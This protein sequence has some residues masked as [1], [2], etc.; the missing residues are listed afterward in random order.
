[1]PP[2]KCRDCDRPQCH[3]VLGCT[4]P[5][6]SPRT[7][8][9][10]STMIIVAINTNHGTNSIKLRLPVRLSSTAPTTPPRT[11]GTRRSHNH[12]CPNTP[13]NWLR[14]R[15]TAAG[16]A[17]N[18]ATALVASAVTGAT[19]SISQWECDQP[20]PTGQ[21]VDRSRHNIGQKQKD[22]G[23]R[24]LFLLILKELRLPAERIPHGR[25]FTGRG[26]RSTA[27]CRDL[28]CHR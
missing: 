28:H 8:I 2:G 16:Y 5:L 20:A 21:R 4:L 3:R 24:C 15:Q 10:L 9:G 23:Y 7:R 27:M 11:H 6:S 26:Y 13:S 19:V 14:V 18:K 17:K 22:V 25:G 1:M 12:P